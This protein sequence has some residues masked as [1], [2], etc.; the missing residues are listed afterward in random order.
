MTTHLRLLS[1]AL[2]FGLLLAAAPNADAQPVP[3]AR[4]LAV[5]G[6]IGVFLPSDD[7]TDGS[8]IFGGFAEYYF[9]PRLSIRGSLSTTRPEYSRGTDEQERQHRLGAD[10][11]YNWEHGKIHPFAGGGL[12]I[13]FMR[14]YDNG[15]N[16]GPN[17]TEVGVSGLG[18][19]EVFLNRAWTFKVE[20]RY[21]W[22]DDRPLY[23]PDGFALTFGVKR[24]F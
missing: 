14:F 10:V 6:D 1:V 5:G 12:G 21:Q 20:G 16:I 9:T 11:I 3:N 22:V 8:V 2:L 23:D 15:D 24:Y 18:G 19:V 13:H 4:Q 7:Q 17:D